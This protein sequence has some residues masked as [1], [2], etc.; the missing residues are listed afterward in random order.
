MAQ[1][2]DDLAEHFVCGVIPHPSIHLEDYLGR[3]AVSLCEKVKR[4]ILLMPA[5]NDPQGYLVGGAMYTAM[6]KHNPETETILFKDVQHGWVP[7]GDLTNPIIKENVE[8]ALD[9]AYA[10]FAKFF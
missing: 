2:F 5:G 1:A 6:K 7:R 9:R 8:A 3:S 10:Y 4:P